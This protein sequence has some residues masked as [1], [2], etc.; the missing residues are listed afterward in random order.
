MLS[1]VCHSQTPIQIEQYTFACRNPYVCGEVQECCVAACSPCMSWWVSCSARH[2]FKRRAADSGRG[3][4]FRYCSICAV[5]LLKF[6]PSVR[7]RETTLEM[8]KGFYEILCW[9]VILNLSNYVN[10]L[11]T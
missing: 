10:F 8:L 2:I 7:T 9:R 5:C 6:R 3:T 11:F 4:A 1:P